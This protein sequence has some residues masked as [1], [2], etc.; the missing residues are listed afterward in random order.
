MKT[1]NI[2]KIL[3]FSVLCLALADVL[4]AQD[5]L[6]H[7]YSA[8]ISAESPA[9]G[10]FS[11]TYAGSR[12]RNDFG[13]KELMFAD[14][15]GMFSFRKNAVFLSVNHY[16]YANYGD[17]RMSAGYGRNFGDRFAMTARVFY[18][19]AHARGYPP[20]HS[21][22]A[23]FAVACKV[24][25]KLLLDAAAYNPFML[26]YGVVGQEVIPMRFVVGCAYLPT[27][28]L[29]VSLR[30]SKTLPGEWEVGCRVMSQPAQPLLVA[31]ECTNSHL[32]LLV[33]WL[34]GR[35]L[36]SV[37]AAWHYRISVSPQLAVEY[38]GGGT[39]VNSRSQ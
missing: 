29:L 27:R 26:R 6:M 24:T 28:K 4:W 11:P 38:F 21:L 35:F 8:E 23:D 16:G 9:A 2:V 17:F 18:L 30:M 33:G 15:F 19:M 22:S 36:L 5:A 25:S 7:A 34:C 20:R 3:V 32:G 12:F 37:Q 1:K 14:V 10:C 31:A 13:M 39:E